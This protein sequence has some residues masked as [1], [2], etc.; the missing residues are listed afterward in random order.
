MKKRGAS[1]IWAIIVSMVLFT[2]AVTTSNFVMKESQMSVRMDDSAQAYAAAETGIEWG[3]YCLGL[4]PKCA[5]SP[6][7]TPYGPF[8]LATATYKVT[9]S[10]SGTK[11]EST[12]TSNGVNRKLEY[13]VTPNQPFQNANGL[14][15]FTAPGSYVQQFDY[16]TDG[17]TEHRIGISNGDATRT[18]FLHYKAGSISLEADTPVLKVS[19]STVDTEILGDIS[20]PYSARVRIEYT[21]GLLAKMTIMKRNDSGTFDCVSPILV[22][23]LE[24]IDFSGLKQFYFW[25]T[26]DAG[27]YGG[28]GTGR[29][30]SS[31]EIYFDNMATKGLSLITNCVLGGCNS[32]FV[33][34]VVPGSMKSGQVYSVSVTMRNS[35]TKSWN[36][37]DPTSPFS[38][39]SQNLQDNTTWGLK[40]VGI[41]KVVNPNENITFTFNVT[42]PT[43]AVA[44]P[45][46]FAWKMV[47]DTKTWFG[48]TMSQSVTVSP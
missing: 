44:T 48:V 16:W 14:D 5:D 25:S 31:G 4:T 3:K 41:P 17:L 33:S 7:N 18:I 30:L 11:I 13:I 36:N 43:V 22:L 39:G 35:G 12:G 37:G 8:T 2:I 29:K 40:R 27:V 9:I 6:I 38:L 20:E 19:E 45:I 24:N 26:L 15:N 47:Q 34:S 23:P 42:A 21:K 32:V 28:N 1:L 46:S 10:L